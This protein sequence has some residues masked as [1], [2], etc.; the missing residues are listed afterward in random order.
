VSLRFYSLSFGSHMLLDMEWIG[1]SMDT[2][3]IPL[4]VHTSTV[5]SFAFLSLHSL[6]YT[7]TVVYLV[8]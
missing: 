6:L 8:A 7:P 1:S 2:P 5:G 3:G 4:V